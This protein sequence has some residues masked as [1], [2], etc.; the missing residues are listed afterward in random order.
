MVIVS[1][2][3]AIPVV[4]CAALLLFLP[5]IA[6]ALALRFR[7]FPA[8]ALAPV[9][10]TAVCGAF[11]IIL[12]WLNIPWSPGM[13][14]LMA[15]LTAGVG[16]LATR[17]LA[18]PQGPT[19]RSISS[20]LPFLAVAAGA[21]VAAVRLMQL[22]GAPGN[23][24]QVFDNIFHL[25]AIRYVLETG[26]ASSLT[27]ASFQGFTGL[28]AVY[29]A[30]WHGFVAMTVQLSG[31]EIQVA[32]NAVNLA[33]GALVWPLSCVFFVRTVISRHP[34][35]LFTAGVLSSGQV[36]F[37]YLILVWGPLFPNALAVSL[38]PTTL[39]I[40]AVLTGVARERPEAKCNWWFALVLSLAGLGTAHMSSFN[41][42]L[43]FSLPALAVSWWRYF[44]SH[45]TE[46]LGSWRIYAFALATVGAV[47]FAALSW[48]RLRPAPYDNWGPTATPLVAV[49]DALTNS[50]MQ[51]SPAWTVSILAI[52]GVVAALR[53]PRHRWIIAS[54]AAAVGLYIVDAAGEK[55]FWRDFLTGTWYQDTNRLAALLPILATPLAAL[56]ALKL[57]ALTTSATRHASF[58]P[59]LTRRTA[60]GSVAALGIL[61]LLASAALG[62]V[63]SYVSSSKAV[64][65]LNPESEI[66]S[67]D[68]MALIKRLGQTVPP[69]ARIAD[70]PW[71]GS[72]L[73]YAF[74]NREVLTP[75]LFTNPDSARTTIS[76]NLKFD[77]FDPAVCA[78][79]KSKN[80]GYVLDFGDRYLLDLPP[81]NDY[82]GVTDIGSSPG[83]E[84]VDSQG[85]EAKLF[86]ITACR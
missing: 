31:A 19:V 15:A 68:E 9:F 51:T 64:Y 75:H 81:S 85:P 45:R 24:A 56:G 46:M 61:G 86:K 44:R 84:L 30:A 35:A 20:A 36:A 27:L 66:L 72:S 39:A 53:A 5:G 67:R 73:A 3:S 55:G 74:G 26:N 32:Q 63:R 69:E 29:P 22:F 33:V 28:D 80:V 41:S 83:F 50:P 82:P 21:A 62:P 16:F 11:G 6:V 34:V 60:L 54:Y 40:V 12:S 78:A 77:P 48:L 71:N 14:G 1:W 59:W 18:I 4:V 47:L 76:K 13:F 2:V 17:R 23:I 79:L 58:S 38:L 52:T 25:N 43:V 65:G 57:W 49:G 7:G 42:L 10:S 37:P 70:N 8:L